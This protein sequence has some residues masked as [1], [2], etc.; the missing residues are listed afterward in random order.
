M[1]MEGGG[2]G[3]IVDVRFGDAVFDVVDGVVGDKNCD[4]ASAPGDCAVAAS[5]AASCLETVHLQLVG[6]G[7]TGLGQP[8]ADVLALVALQLENFAVLGVLD[9][10]AVACKLLRKSRCDQTC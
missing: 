5:A 3:Q 1:L 2:S 9:D 10:R 8:L 4:S 6:L 7:Q